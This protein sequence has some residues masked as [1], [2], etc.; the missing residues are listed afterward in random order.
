MQ[1]RR[2]APYLANQGSIGAPLVVSAG[3]W[4]DEDE[5]VGM[6]VVVV[7][8]GAVADDDARWLENAALVIAADGGASALE[9]L[10]RRPD[11]L[12]GDLDSADAGLVQRLEAAGVEVRRHPT[13][14]EATDTELAVDAAL[15]AGATEVV[16]LGAL[17]GRRLDH[18]LANLLLLADAHL[19]SIDTRIVHGPTT[20]RLLPG[21]RTA[22]LAGAPGGL[23]S[24]L[25]IGGDAV[26]VTTAGLRWTLDGATLPLGASRGVSNEILTIPASVSLE[27]GQLLLVET[28][29][30]GAIHS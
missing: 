2:G 20:T 3:P 13:D 8:S 7:A 21:G 28:D 15:V 10:S 14:K 4:S 6:L 30:E 17:G 16:I 26:G 18:E 24:L 19:G 1:H 11:L 9:R 29:M 5:V 12:V 25:P 27:H 23:V 22:R